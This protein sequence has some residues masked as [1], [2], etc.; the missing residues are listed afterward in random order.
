MRLLGSQAEEAG[1][2]QARCTACRLDEHKEKKYHIPSKCSELE[3]HSP[4]SHP[5][6]PR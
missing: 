4:F 2:Q 1:F 5:N 3:E 6:H